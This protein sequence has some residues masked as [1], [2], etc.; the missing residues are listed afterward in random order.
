MTKRAR[1]REKAG[2]VTDLNGY[3]EQRVSEEHRSTTAAFEE[4]PA[5]EDFAMIRRA[6]VE[7]WPVRQTAK[8]PLADML[9]RMALTDSE[10]TGDRIHAVKALLAMDSMNQRDE[11]LAIQSITPRLHLHGQTVIPIEDSRALILE[12]IDQEL[13]E[14]GVPEEGHEGNGDSQPTNGESQAPPPPA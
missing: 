2:R 14:R 6:V 3:K 4:V 8:G 9:I 1:Q 11:H 12:A 10:K 5:L 7:R 13:S